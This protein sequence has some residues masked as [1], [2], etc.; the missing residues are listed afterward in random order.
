MNRLLRTFAPAGAVFV[1]LTGS[2]FAQG[3][4]IGQNGVS[5]SPFATQQKRP[6]T[7]EEVEKQQQL[8]D[9]YKAAQ[10]KIPDQQTADPWGGVRNS[11]SAAAAPAA[12]KKPPVKTAQPQP[13]VK[14]A[15]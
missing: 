3:I 9:A 13:A 15:Q 14:T 10:K 7:Q 8:D 11:T 5:V 6:L 2:V 4:G 1:L 12:K